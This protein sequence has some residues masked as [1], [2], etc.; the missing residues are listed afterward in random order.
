MDERDGGIVIRIEGD[1]S[2]HGGVP[3]VDPL[4]VALDRSSSGDLR[5]DASELGSWDSALLTFLTRLSEAAAERGV[6]E[7]REGL[8]EGVR[9]L[10][11]LAEAVPEKEGT[12]RGEETGRLVTRVGLT[13]IE[14]TRGMHA[15]VEFV[16]EVTIALGKW[17]TGRASYRRSDL[18]L[19]VQQAG[20]SGIC[21]KPFD[22]PSVKRMIRQL[23]A[24]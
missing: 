8:P 12:D 10:L 6:V 14:V 18:W 22:T 24:A 3:D 19:A 4:L 20:V 17:V 2:I 23:L 7:E 9:G 11:R 1:W 13:T 15:M 5:F 16:G 21:D